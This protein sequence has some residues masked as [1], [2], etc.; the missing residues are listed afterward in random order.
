MSKKEDLKIW[1]KKIREL[2]VDRQRALYDHNYPLAAHLKRT[3]QTL[4]AQKRHLEENSD[5]S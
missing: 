3:L 2:N 5:E 4:E 1:D